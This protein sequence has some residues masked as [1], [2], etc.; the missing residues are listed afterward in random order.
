MVRG[1]ADRLWRR[2]RTSGRA[3]AKSEDS[4]A[5]AVRRPGRN[6]STGDHRGKA[7]TPTVAHAVLRAVSRFVSTFRLNVATNGDAARKTACATVGLAIAVLALTA[8]NNLPGRPG[9]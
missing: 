4:P 6:R 1:L 8:C 3:A 2:R 7:M 5:H 9:P